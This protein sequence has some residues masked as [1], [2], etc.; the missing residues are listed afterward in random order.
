MKPYI[1]LLSLLLFL[2][3][4][5]VQAH[6]FHATVASVEVVTLPT[7][8]STQPNTTDTS[9]TTI[10]TELSQSKEPPSPRL[11]KPSSPLKAVSSH[12]CEDYRQAVEAYFGAQTDTA[13]FI[14][15]KESGCRPDAVSSVNRDGLRDYCF[16]QI[17]GE[18]ETKDNLDLCIRRAYEKYIN[19]GNWSAWFSVCSTS[20]KP[21]YADIKC[22]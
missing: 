15:S 14:A 2:I 10:K 9:S 16:F 5:P 11:T 21:K 7:Q 1:C 13:L 4:Q 22:E 3:P 17:H 6:Q 19:R 20:K 8:L 12:K 18:P